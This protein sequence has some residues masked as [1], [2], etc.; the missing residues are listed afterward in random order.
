MGGYC[1]LS[2][3]ANAIRIFCEVDEVIILSDVCNKKSD[4]GMRDNAIMFDG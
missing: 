2:K 1:D 4:G 3:H